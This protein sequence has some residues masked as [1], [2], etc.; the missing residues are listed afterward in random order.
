MQKLGLLALLIKI[1]NIL[2]NRKKEKKRREK[3]RRE[4]RGGGTE[5]FYAMHAS[6][7]S[8]LR[9][10]YLQGRRPVGQVRKKHKI[11]LIQDCFLPEVSG[12]CSGSIL[13]DT[14]VQGS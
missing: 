5:R 14:R 13:I 3:K 7:V 2:M 4:K 1:T 10:I 9:Y 6:I 11:R 8:V 12:S